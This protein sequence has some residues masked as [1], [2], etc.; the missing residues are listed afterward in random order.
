MGFE[1][2]EG[3]LSGVVLPLSSRNRLSAFRPLLPVALAVLNGRCRPG[4][5]RWRG[6]QLECSSSVARD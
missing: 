4:N 5:R 3:Q 1:A 6:R 2:N